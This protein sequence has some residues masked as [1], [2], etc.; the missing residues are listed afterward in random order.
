MKRFVGW[1]ILSILLVFILSFPF[2]V[3]LAKAGT[4]VVPDDYT[5]IQAAI[6]AALPG[7]T[8]FV[9]KGIYHENLFIS[10]ALSLV[11]E[12]WQQTI[13][14]GGGAGHVVYIKADNVKVTGFTFKNSSSEYPYSGIY[15]DESHG[16]HIYGNNITAMYYGIRIYNSS[17]NYVS[18]NYISRVYGSSSSTIGIELAWSCNNTINCNYLHIYYIGI[19]LAESRNNFVERNILQP[20]YSGGYAF[21]VE[22]NSDF[23]T[24]LNNNVTTSHEPGYY[25]CY[26][27]YGFYISDS[28]CNVLQGNK[29]HASFACIYLYASNNTIMVENDFIDADYALSLIY[30]NFCVFYH[31]NIFR[32]RIQF[33]WGDL[34]GNLWDNGY[35]SGGN[36]WEDQWPKSDY[37]SSPNQ[38]QPGSDGIVDTPYDLGYSNKDRYPFMNL[39]REPCFEVSAAPQS[40]KFYGPQT[41]SYTIIITSV[42]SFILPVNLSCSWFGATPPGVT[43]SLSR[44]TITPPPNGKDISNLTVTASS[45]AVAGSYT[46]RITGTSGSLT[47]YV[48]IVVTVLSASLDITPPEIGEPVQTPSNNTIQPTEKVKISVNVTDDESG[49]SQVILSY[50]TDNG[51]TWTNLNMQLNATT[52]SYEIEVREQQPGTVVKYKIIAYDNAGNNATKDN[53]GYYYTYQVIPE[54]PSTVALA[55]FLLTTLIATALLITK[56]KSANPLI[57]SF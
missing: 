10:K 16:C 14:D 51:T 54:F 39:Y 4:I 30:S 8:V 50:T 48:D 7:D 27:S 3:K 6:D 32:G 21:D 52:N 34:I 5:T 45:T 25:E 15:L 36:Y 29:M 24:F 35:P 31:N 26:F 20:Y 55:V 11:G 41:K 53:N 37:Y 42:N 49:I 56:R 17:N 23:N 40:Q 43:F 38:D 22:Y 57:S 12:D 9:R 1:T 2:S 18:Q 47:N 44:S 46:L 13:I 28:V 33:P 19:K